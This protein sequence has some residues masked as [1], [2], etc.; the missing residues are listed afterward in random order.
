MVTVVTSPP[1]S[2]LS[3]REVIDKYPEVSPFVILKIDVQRR[4]L[5]YG[6]TT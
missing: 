4:S 2:A 5:S 6:P 1:T 3:R